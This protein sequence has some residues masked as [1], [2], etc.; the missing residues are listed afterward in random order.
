[1]MF[2]V[3]TQCQRGLLEWRSR[4]LCLEKANWSIIKNGFEATNA[5]DKPAE[6]VLEIVWMHLLCHSVQLI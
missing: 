5:K 4:H 3:Y 2:S 1:M 6:V